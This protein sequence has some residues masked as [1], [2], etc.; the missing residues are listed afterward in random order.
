MVAQQKSPRNNAGFIYILKPLISIDGKDV[1]KIGMTK[2]PVAERV[3]ELTTGSIVPLKIVYSLHVENAAK[4]ERQL[5]TQ[6]HARR[7][8]GGGQE[9]FDVSADEVIAEV[10]PDQKS[11]V[12]RRL[13]S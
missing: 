2:R 13:Q 12:V 5:H 8:V 1:V 6:F 10:L 11:E 3:R 4:L 9:F 7:L